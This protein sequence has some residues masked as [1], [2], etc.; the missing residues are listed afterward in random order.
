M[1]LTD[2]FTGIIFNPPDQ[3]FGKTQKAFY[4]VAALA[5]GL[6]KPE[7]AYFIDDSVL[8]VFMSMNCGWHGM[9]YYHPR[10]HKTLPG[11]YENFKTLVSRISYLKHIR[12]IHPELFAKSKQ[13]GT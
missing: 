9:I 13:G 11:Y 12:K 8:N 1:G 2:Y 3:N 5:T 7:Y 10:Y 4:D 6:K